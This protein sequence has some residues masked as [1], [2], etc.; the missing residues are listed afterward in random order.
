MTE[1][2]R[3][4]T[5]TVVLETH[6]LTE[7]TDRDRFRAVVRA[8]LA[9]E[10]E[11]G[12][13]E[14]L[15]CDNSAR[16]EIAAFMS[17][18]FPQIRRIDTTGL[19]YDQSK[20]M[21]ARVTLSRYLLFLDGDCL[22]E[23]EWHRHLLG[24]LA[25]GQAAACAG[26]T[27]YEGGFFAA[28]MTI[29]D[30]GFFFPLSSRNLGCYAFNNCGF[31]RELLEAIPYPHADMRCSC[32]AHAQLLCRNGTPARLVPQARAL[33][34]LP[35]LIRERTRQG[36]DAIAACWGNPDLPEAQW[37]RWGIWA[38][39]RFYARAVHLDWQRTFRGRKNLWIATWTIILALPL[40]PIFRILDALGM[41]RA[42]L[43]GPVK[44]G[45]A[46]WER[47]RWVCATTR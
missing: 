21:A 1:T 33:H 25:S 10:T 39:P 36:Y 45:W 42:F 40:F 34:A 27:R 16:P 2:R 28:I 26:Y 3:S 38:L 43:R 31:L 9:M 47:K 7:G 35:P 29:L 44:G 32:F 37:L 15:V 18:E 22:P 8:A 23:P 41:V 17:R 5:F 30:F 4:T 11:D 46:G 6:N 12:Q 20:A 14:V 24:W 13:A 19:G